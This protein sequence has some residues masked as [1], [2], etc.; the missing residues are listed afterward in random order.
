MTTSKIE[1]EHD[2]YSVADKRGSLLF[3]SPGMR[4]AEELL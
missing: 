1:A 2:D 4:M 3:A